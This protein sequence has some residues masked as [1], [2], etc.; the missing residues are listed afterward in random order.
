MT[1]KL[2]H[3]KAVEIPIAIATKNQV[4]GLQVLRKIKA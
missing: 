2:T 4:G 3:R 1:T